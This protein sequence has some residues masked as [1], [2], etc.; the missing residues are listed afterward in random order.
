MS[1]KPDFF[2]VGAP[3]AGTTSLYHYLIQHPDISMTDPKEPHFFYNRRSPGE[4]VLGEK[5]LSE[6]LKL[7]EE[8]PEGRRAG[9]ASTSYLWLTNAAREIK[10]LQ[11]EAKIIILL[12]DPVKRAYSH[13]WHHVRDDKE[14]LGFKEALEAEPGRMEQGAWHGFY[15]VG[16]GLY[17]E[18]VER[19]LDTFGRESVKVYLFED[20]MENP[21]GVCRDVFGFLGVDPEVAVDTGAIYNRGGAPKNRLFHKVIRSRFKEPLKKLM[22]AGFRRS[23]GDRIR[24][25][26]IK[27]APAMEPETRRLLEEAFREDLPRLEELLGRDLARW[28]DR[29]KGLQHSS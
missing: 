24:T 3:K 9:E 5:D 28:K 26:N 19:Y 15:Y 11:P 10:E 2:V 21:R 8:A 14:P 22:P 25:S 16:C 6:Y 7:F 1:R 13:Y 23:L 12:R 17:A 18:Q 27:P 4:P 20:L 29:A